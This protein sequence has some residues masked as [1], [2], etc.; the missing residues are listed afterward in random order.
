[1][2]TREVIHNVQL[3]GGGLA[4]ISAAGL[5]Y[6]VS[7]GLNKKLYSRS[8]EPDTVEELKGKII[9][10]KQTEE[11][12]DEMRGVY[13]LVQAKDEALRVDVGPSWFVNHQERKFKR[14]DKITIK[15]SRVKFNGKEAI[16]AMSIVRDG[17]LF[18]LRD[19]KG[20]PYWHAWSKAG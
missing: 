9:E 19:E 20:N 18:R 17:E 16:V 4:L 10:V 3:I 6:A 15:G 11:K 8:F 7:R 2:N 5:A 12:K 14:G 1:M 13:F